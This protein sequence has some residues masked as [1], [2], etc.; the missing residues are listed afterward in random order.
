[1]YLCTP[2]ALI[3]LY[4]LLKLKYFNNE[5]FIA[6]QDEVTENHQES[7]KAIVIADVYNSNNYQYLLDEKRWTK[8]NKFP[9]AITYIRGILEIINVFYVIGNKEISTLNN[10]VYKFPSNKDYDWCATYP[11]GNNIFVVCKE[12][13]YDDDVES[14][15]FNPINKQWSGIDIRIKE[16]YFAVVYYLNKIFIVG[17]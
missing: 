11:V 12:N 3:Y 10:E 14:S 8:L 17:G 4:R 6:Q 2:K 9:E 15:I 13:W 1:M 16:R 7:P 5:N